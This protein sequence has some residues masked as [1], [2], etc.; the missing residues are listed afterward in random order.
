MR[1]LATL[2]VVIALG[3][4]LSYPAYSQQAA[5]IQRI[6]FLG[7]TPP[8][9]PTLLDVLRRALADLG[10]VEG[11]HITIENRWP[12]GDRLDLLPEAAAA[13]VI[14]KPEVIVAI[15]AT[16]ARAAMAATTDIP[17]IFA[18]VVDP[19]ATGLTTNLEQPGGSVTGLTTFD[20][21][22]ARR[23]LEI[24]K[25][26]IPGLARVALLGDAG[27]APA[28]F[29]V[30]EDAA[31]ALGLQPL[32][33][34]VAR[35]P[36][37]DFAGALEAA[38]SAGAGAIVVLSTPVT[39]PHRKLIAEL[40][41]KHRLPTLSPRDHEDAGGLISYGV[42][43]SE[44]T[45]RAAD[46]VEKILKGAKAGSLS[47]ETVRQPELIINLKTAREIGVTFSPAM[48]TKATRIIE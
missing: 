38:R 45:R 8:A 25:E 34:K 24:L 39:T 19:V 15:G 37:P 41:A 7:P 3:A 23:Q 4:V 33:F 35:A 18:V 10:L 29:Q 9:P 12:D 32:S 14:L 16:A 17:I 48:L 43:F 26:A 31:R 22:Q 44:L 2:I 27:A 46:Y 36:H 1:R 13:L 5:Q 11:R 21:Q 47:V 28:L 42:S 30:N 40:A 20:P 6:G